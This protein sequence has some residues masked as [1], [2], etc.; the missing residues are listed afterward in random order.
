MFG[1]M[2]GTIS[3]TR[4][5]TPL[6]PRGL[7][8]AVQ[9]NEPTKVKSPGHGLADMSQ[10]PTESNLDIKPGTYLLTVSEHHNQAFSCQQSTTSIFHTYL[11]FF[12][13]NIHLITTS[14]TMKFTSTLALTAALVAGASAKLH[15]FG[16]CYYGPTTAVSAHHACYN[17]SCSTSS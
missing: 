2:T 12:T 6:V 5:S 8:G 3:T 10:I 9:R 17:D 11:K 14:I 16:L 15:Q 1:V 13:S 4:L 7:C